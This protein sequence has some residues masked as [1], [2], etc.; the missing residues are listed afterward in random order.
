VALG[1]PH[2]AWARCEVKHSQNGWP[3]ARPAY[4]EYAR[5][6]RGSRFRW[7][8]VDG[9][10]SGPKIDRALAGCKFS[11]VPAAMEWMAA[12]DWARNVEA[13]RE[14]SDLRDDEKVR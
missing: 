11:T 12:R 5:N 7:V 2:W 1:V 6:E 14:W 8:T 9:L 3:K 13:L 10:S 4:L